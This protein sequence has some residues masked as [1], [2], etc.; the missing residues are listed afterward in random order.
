M[1]GSPWSVRVLAISGEV[2]CPGPREDGAYLAMRS[3]RSLQRQPEGKGGAQP[4]STLH[5][6]LA[7]MGDHM[8]EETAVFGD[9]ETVALG[10]EER[11]Q[12]GVDVPIIAMPRA[13]LKDVERVLGTLVGR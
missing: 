3:A 4:L 7:A 8:L 5:H 1:W 13:P 12:A 9:I 11:R 6:H 2:S 10:L